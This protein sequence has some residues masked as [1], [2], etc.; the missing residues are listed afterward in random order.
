MI[1]VDL[2][3]I[4][5]SN[6]MVSLNSKYTQDLELNEDLIR[7]MVL[8][9][10]RMYRVK[11][12]EKYGEL[13]ICCDNR[14]YWRKEVFP[15]YKAPRKKVRLS[16][17]YDWNLI[18]ETLNN[19]RDELKEHF[20][21][22]VIDIY[23]AEA[24]DIIAVLVANR[25]VQSDLTLILSG[26]KD[27]MQLQFY[28]NVDQYSPVQKK[29][30]RTDHPSDF[31][32]EHIFRGDRSDGIPNCLSSDSVFVQG[33]RQT[34]LSTKKLKKWMPEVSIDQVD[35]PDS[36]DENA[37]RGFCRNRELI[38]MNYVPDDIKQNILNVYDTCKPASRSGLLS[39][40]I[41]KRLKNLM[42][43]TQDF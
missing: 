18:F 37:W 32:K 4:A 31:L 38:S 29:F 1:L 40:F 25:E 41:G 8:N 16:S 10:L 21:Y 5:I 6:L 22:R 42:N 9:S 11:F 27:F 7:H 17:D 35:K 36:M 39:F 3:Q 2:N 14:H 23:G 43:C 12:Q 28:P 13:V 26:D 20:P 15:F 30:L 34:P 19:I 24:D 33:R